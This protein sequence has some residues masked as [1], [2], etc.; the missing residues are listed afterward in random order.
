MVTA[1]RLAGSRRASVMVGIFEWRGVTAAQHDVEVVA[2]GLTGNG[3]VQ[4]EL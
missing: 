2:E 4:I 1:V 3:G